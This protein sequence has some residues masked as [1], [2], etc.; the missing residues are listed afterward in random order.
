MKKSLKVLQAR[1]FIK[2]VLLIN[3]SALEGYVAQARLQAQQSF[4]LS[5]N[6]AIVGFAIV[7]F[8]IGLGVFLTVFNNLNLNSAYLAAVSGVLTEFIAGVFFILY[9]KTLAQITLFHDKLVDLQ[10]T[11]MVYISEKEK[12]DERASEGPILV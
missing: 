6:V 10:K 3:I 7:A 1:M 11:A 4:N 12:K 5:K 8:S 9:S 2:Y